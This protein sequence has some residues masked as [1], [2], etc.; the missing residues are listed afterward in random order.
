MKPANGIRIRP[1]RPADLDA[2][3]ALEDCCFAADERFS[4]RQFAHLLRR[5]L[6]AGTA[7][8]L[9]AVAADRSIVASAIFLLRRNSRVARLYSIAVS[10][11]ARGQGLGAALLRAAARRLR[12][13]GFRAIS[14]EVREDNAAARR[15][16]ER[17]AFTAVQR[18]EA[19]Y[20]GG[21]HGIRYRIDL[22]RAP[23]SS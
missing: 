2:I 17:L 11:A 15:L 16:Y 9:A 8:G 19:Y 7:W 12:T 3:I 22:E 18:L 21:A 20:S 13:C 4:R 14:L 6:P 1:I 10:P 5:A 23:R